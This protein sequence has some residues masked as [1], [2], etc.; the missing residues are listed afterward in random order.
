MSSPVRCAAVADT[1]EGAVVLV[2][3]V[4]D[5]RVPGTPPDSAPVR[6]PMCESCIRH[7]RGQFALLRQTFG[8]AS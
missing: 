2:E 3:I 7:A 6:I 8:G 5:L 4:V 1:H